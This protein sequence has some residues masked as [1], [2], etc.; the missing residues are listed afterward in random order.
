LSLDEHDYDGIRQLFARFSHALDLG[1][2]GGL[3]ECF[4]QDGVLATTLPEEGLGGVHEGRA[5]IREFGG[6]AHQFN[7]ARVRHSAVNTIIEGDGQGA[8]ASSSVLISRDY[9]P[10]NA[11]GHITYSELVTTAMFHDELVRVDGRWLFARR[12][13]QHDGLPVTRGRLGNE[14][15]VGPLPQ[16]SAVAE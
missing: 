15:K 16:T 9:G 11:S 14:V 4:T 2:A 6:R 1:D 8:R 5:A 10:P 3:A 7:A 13:L 12:E